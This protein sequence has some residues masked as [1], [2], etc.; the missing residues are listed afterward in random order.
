LEI[1]YRRQQRKKERKKK[2]EKKEKDKKP[3]LCYAIVEKK[4][5]I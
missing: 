1:D 2:R 4:E 5:K 3:V